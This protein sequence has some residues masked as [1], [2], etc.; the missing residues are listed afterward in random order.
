MVSSEVEEKTERLLRLIFQTGLGGLLINSQPNF[1]WLTAGGTNGID[2]TR[3]NGAGT[4]F[5]RRDGRRFLLANKIE[6]E[7]LLSEELSGQ[8]YEPIDFAWE[9]EKANP[10][11]VVGK[12]R[13]LMSEGLP[14]G[15][16]LSFGGD[17][18]VVENEI[19]SARYELTADEVMR[20]RAL[21]HVWKDWAHD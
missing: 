1:S 14:V 16:D 4:L 2:L 19:A 17:V 6:I 12:A 3:E 13:S 11:I 5:L 21:G 20:F 7:R 18:R 8:G 10:S 15:S 9:D